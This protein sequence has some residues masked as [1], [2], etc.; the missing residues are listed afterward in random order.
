MV[1]LVVEVGVVVP[2]RVPYVGGIGTLLLNPLQRGVM[3]GCGV[4]GR[5]VIQL[6]VLLHVMLLLLLVVLGMLWSRWHGDKLRLS[7]SICE[8]KA[9]LLKLG[10]E[11]FARFWGLKFYF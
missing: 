5:L 8:R 11:I 10:H 2:V 7:R 9:T 4:E 3:G 6:L 1:L